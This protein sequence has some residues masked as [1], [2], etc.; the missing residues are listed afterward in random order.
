MKDPLDQILA[1]LDC[2][3]ISN[4]YIL[5][6]I[7]ITTD[8]ICIDVNR[9]ILDIFLN[10]T[11]DD[12]TDEENDLIQDLFREF[13][14]GHIFCELKVIIDVDRIKKDINEYVD[15]LMKQYFR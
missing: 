1:E 2:E 12:V 8:N 7:I 3:H 10:K 11:P 9:Q 5:K 13:A 4:E 15:S 14:P 6:G